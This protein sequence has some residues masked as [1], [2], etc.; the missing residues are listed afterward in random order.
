MVAIETLSTQAS[1]HMADPFRPKTRTAYTMMFRVFIAFCIIMK[2]SLSY[3]LVKVSLSFFEC[4][5]VNIC[6]VS[7]IC[8]Y[9]SAIKANFIVYDLPFYMCEHP[10]I[11][12]FIK[13]LKINRPLC[14]T[15]HNI[16][17]IQML[18]R[19]CDLALTLPGGQIF[20]AII[21][22]GFFAFLRLSN[23]CQHSVTSFD[24]SRHLC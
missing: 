6:S 22:T 21:L 23:L 4:L 7:M 20:K 10:K 2:V 18:R 24:P 11:K 5:V 14:I 9:A 8:Q 13:S 15:H 12:Y 19:M 16:V 1:S 3:L 17:D